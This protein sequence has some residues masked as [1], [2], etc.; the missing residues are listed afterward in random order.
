MGRG[1]DAGGCG[2]GDVAGVLRLLLGRGLSEKVTDDGLD[3]IEESGDELRVPAGEL[4]GVKMAGRS[5]VATLRL[6]WPLEFRKCGIVR[7]YSR[8]A[9]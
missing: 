2:A 1:S 3:S 8:A 7:W 4:S 5:V 6:N 9:S